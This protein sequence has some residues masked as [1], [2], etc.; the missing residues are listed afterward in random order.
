MSICPDILGVTVS[1]VLVEFQIEFS[2]MYADEYLQTVT[3]SMKRTAHL[4]GLL[5]LPSRYGGRIDGG[6]GN[7]L[8]S[9]NVWFLCSVS[10]RFI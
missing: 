2:P 6:A 1:V 7:D 4:C 5:S 10:G 3:K 9:S 8:V